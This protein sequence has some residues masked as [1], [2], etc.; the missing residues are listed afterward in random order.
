MLIDLKALNLN[1]GKN[2]IDHFDFYTPTCVLYGRNDGGVK[3][4]ISVLKHQDT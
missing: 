4:G 2:K 3:F 1:W